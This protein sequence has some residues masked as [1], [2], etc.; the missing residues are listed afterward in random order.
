MKMDISE[1]SM[2]V[3]GGGREDGCVEWDE[4]GGGQVTHLMFVVQIPKTQAAFYKD[5]EV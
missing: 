4:G 5:T 1:V 3:R 2:C